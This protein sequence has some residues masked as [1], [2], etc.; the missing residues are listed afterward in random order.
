MLYK[1]GKK[2]TF[3]G[4]EY[5]QL[6]FELD[7]LT[8]ADFAAA[9]KEFAGG[10]NFAAVPSADSEFCAVLLARVCKLPREFFA[11]MPV[12]DYCKIT[13]MVSNFLLA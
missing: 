1:F 8:G 2:Y 10:G 9:K 5:E 3:E 11:Q 13:Q 4:V 6:E 12:N 7:N